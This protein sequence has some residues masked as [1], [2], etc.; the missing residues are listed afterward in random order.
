MKKERP[1]TSL[2]KKNKRNQVKKSKQAKQRAE[3]SIS[4]KDGSLFLFRALGKIL[5]CKRE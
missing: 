4:G 2:A 3:D 5:H 1:F